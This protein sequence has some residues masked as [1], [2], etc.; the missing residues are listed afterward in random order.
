[1]MQERYHCSSVFMLLKCA[2][3]AESGQVLL[4][5]ARRHGEGEKRR[6]GDQIT[7]DR[8]QIT[9][10]G[11]QTT[12]CSGQLTAGGVSMEQRSKSHGILEEWKFGIVEKTGQLLDIFLNYTYPTFH[13]S[14]IP[15]FPQPSIDPPGFWI[16]TPGFLLYDQ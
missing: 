4:G 15:I 16:L 5:R 14:S 1:M 3:T 9:K 10:V 13:R 2:V 6:D 8:G 12:D 11:G 7:D